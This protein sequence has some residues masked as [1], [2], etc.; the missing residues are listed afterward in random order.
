MD[1]TPSNAVLLV[2]LESLVD[3]LKAHQISDHE[4]QGAILVQCVKTNGRV[5]SLEAAKNMAWGGI[6]LTNVIILPIAITLLIHY[7]S[8]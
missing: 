1:E 5:T 2:K 7:L 6:I 4:Q 3:L 8:K